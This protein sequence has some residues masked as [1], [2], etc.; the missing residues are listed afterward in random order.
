MCRLGFLFAVTTPETTTDETTAPAAPDDVLRGLRERVSETDRAIVDLVNRRLELV[1]RIKRH[2][3]GPG[4]GFL[5]P[6]REAFLLRSLERTN[7]G[8]LSHPGLAELHAT[9]LA[10]TKKEV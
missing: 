6:E 7:R 4:V 3:D 8:P 10:L 9:L 5:D 2:K 1:R